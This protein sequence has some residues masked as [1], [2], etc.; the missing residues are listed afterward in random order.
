MILTIVIQLVDKAEF[1]LLFS[2]VRKLKEILMP[3]QMVGKHL[4]IRFGCKD[5]R[6]GQPAYIN[7]NNFTV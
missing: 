5:I 6:F 4:N 7:K 1:I 3:I 2:K